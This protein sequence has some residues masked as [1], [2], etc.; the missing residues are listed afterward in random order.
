MAVPP[1]ILDD[2]AS[3]LRIELEGSP[4]VQPGQPLTAKVIPPASDLRATD[5]LSLPASLTWITKSLIFAA[6]QTG[7]QGEPL[8]AHPPVVAGPMPIADVTKKQIG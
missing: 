6:G 8:A 3:V 7:L 4:I 1:A 5:V 2:L